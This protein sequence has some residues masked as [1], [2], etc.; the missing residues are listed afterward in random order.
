VE[1]RS[2]NV[3]ADVDLAIISGIVDGVRDELESCQP[4][5]GGTI[6]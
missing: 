4:P 6:N 1:F 2:S 5:K 3:H